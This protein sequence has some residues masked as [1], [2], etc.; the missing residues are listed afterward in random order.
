MD[1]AAKIVVVL[2]VTA[3]SGFFIYSKIAGWHKDKLDTVI[4]FE[5][6]SEIPLV[7]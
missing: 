5:L 3:A 6:A 1:R 4:D 7:P 2:L